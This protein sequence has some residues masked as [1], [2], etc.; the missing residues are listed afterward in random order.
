MLNEIKL[1]WIALV[2]NEVNILT[3]I[4]PCF[5]EE[6]VIF[7]TA[8][9]ITSILT[10]LIKNQKISKKSRIL[11]V[12]DGSRDNTWSCIESLNDSNKYVSGIKFSRNFGHQNALIAGLTMVEQSTSIAIT[13]DADLQDDINIIPKMVDEYL[14]GSD[15]V[16]GVRNNRKTDTWFKKYS[17]ET[18]YRL[19]EHFGV[20]MV[21]NHADYRLMSKRAIHALLKYRERNLFLRG[22]VPLV[23]YPSTKVYYMRKERY[24][25]KSKYPL[26]KMLNFAFDG[27]SSF[28]LAPIRIIMYLG[29]ASIILSIALMVYTLIQRFL[30]NTTTGW[31]SL[32]I[33]IWFLGG[34]QLT[35]LSIIGEYIGKVFTEVKQRP[36]YQIEKTVNSKTQIDMTTK[37]ASLTGQKIS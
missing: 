29:F 9:E 1:G 19:M 24:A 3:I 7:E 26:K 37:K 27:I 10:Q 14:E 35:S 15:V 2:N 23:G 4:I 8:K 17:A 12:D 31:P 18:F 6:E 30:G 5:N 34:V 25:G 33:S 22:I 13:I 11:F 16:Y 20:K 28:S 32:M 36:R 21:Y